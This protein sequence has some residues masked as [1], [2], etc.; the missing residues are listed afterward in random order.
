MQ[1]KKPDFFIIASG[2]NYTVEYFVKKCFSY[3]GLD[4]KKYV[5]I[6]PKLIRK[7]QTSSLRGNTLKAEKLF[8]FNKKKTSLDQLIKIMMDS[9]LNKVN[10]T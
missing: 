5:K 9:E 7:A 8:K 1:L 10:G 4:Y 2:T 6:D 3:V